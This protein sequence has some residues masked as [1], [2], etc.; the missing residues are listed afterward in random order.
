MTEAEKRFKES[1]LNKIKKYEIKE[2]KKNVTIND[3][4]KHAKNQFVETVY[5]NG[6]KELIDIGI[7][8]YLC[9]CSPYYF[10]SK[11]CSFTL[12]GVGE[13][14]AETLYYYQ[15]EILKDFINWKKVVL[16]KSRQ[17]GLST[18]MAL[19]F[20]WKIIFFPK[21]W[22]VIISKDGTSAED[23]LGKIKENL[24]NYNQ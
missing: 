5:Y 9:Q 10:I 13:F 6:E 18:L 1:I 7:E 4:L 3:C 21:E 15:K 22:G 11:Y 23:V 8:K 14:S 24:K 17:T 16:T 12:P 19:I 2:K 20:F